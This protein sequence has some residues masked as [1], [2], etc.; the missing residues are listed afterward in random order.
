MHDDGVRLFVEVGPSSNL[1]AFV[2]D[3]LIDRQFV[4]FPPTY[5]ARA[6]SSSF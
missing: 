3:I 5:A 2:S 1:T 6:A 4:A